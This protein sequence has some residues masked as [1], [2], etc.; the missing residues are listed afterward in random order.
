[1]VTWLLEANPGVPAGMQV[2][3]TGKGRRGR[4]VDVE[5]GPHYFLS[6][7]LISSL[8]IPEYVYFYSMV[9]FLAPMYHLYLIIGTSLF[10]S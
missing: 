10:F 5:V 4:G 8:L 7:F 3:F 9:Y 6:S 2:G 1:M